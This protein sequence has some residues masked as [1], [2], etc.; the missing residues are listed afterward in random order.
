MGIA[1]A[2]GSQ[3]FR[4]WNSGMDL[5]LCTSHRAGVTCCHFYFFLVFRQSSNCLRYLLAFLVLFLDG[6]E[7]KYKG[8]GDFRNGGSVVGV[9]LRNHDEN[10]NYVHIRQGLYVRHLER[11]A[12]S[13]H[14]D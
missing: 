9:V 10:K 11:I 8:G 2:M 7:C 4:P 6:L 1:Y 3:R 5:A 12:S 14:W 13:H